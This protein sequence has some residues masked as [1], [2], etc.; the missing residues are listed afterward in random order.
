[1]P[2]VVQSVRI[3]LKPRN[4]LPTL[5]GFLLGGFVPLACFILAHHE[6]A[7]WSAQGG[8]ALGLVGGGLVYSAT[9]VYGWAKQAFVSA[10]KASGF[11][12]LVEGV[13]ITSTTAW[14]SIA[15]LVYLVVINGVATG[16]TLSI[17]KRT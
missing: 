8:R 16:V 7:A 13:M 2:G 17:G 14:L 11:V 1:M 9:T 3:A 12:V 4:R 10:F 15:A 6:H 5:I